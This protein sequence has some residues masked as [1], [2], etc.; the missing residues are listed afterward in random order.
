MI[1]S[2]KMKLPKETTVT[3]TIEMTVEEMRGLY[4]SIR[5]VTAWPTSSFK[6]VLSQSLA[7]AEQAYF[8]EHVVSP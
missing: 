6:A 5:E 3:L 7:K 2:A 1:A 4:T 8:S